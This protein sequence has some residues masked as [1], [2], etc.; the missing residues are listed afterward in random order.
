MPLNLIEE[1]KRHFAFDSF[2][3]G[4]LEAIQHVLNRQNT[5]VVMPTGAGKSLCYQLPALLNSDTTL[6]VSP[7]IALMKDQVEALQSSGKTAT[8]I[9]SSLTGP[10]Q[11][12]RVQAMRAGQF[13]LVY[14][15][16]ERFR[17]NAFLAAMADVA[18]SLFVV[19]EAHCI[20]QWGHDFRPDYL[21]LKNVISQVRNPTVAALTATATVKVQDDIIR[22][23]GLKSCEK[24]ITGF[25]R[26]NLTFEVEYTPDDA[27]KLRIIEELLTS[28][29]DSGIIYTGTRR[30]A[31][32]VAEFVAQYCK[33]KTDFYHAGLESYDRSRIQD[34]FMNDEISVIVATNAFGMGVDKSDIRYVIH[35][36]LPSSLEA[37]YQEAGRAGRDGKLSRCVLLYSPKDRALQEWFIENDAPTKE[38]LKGLYE[39]IKNAA[40]DR[41]V[42]IGLGYLQRMT[43][44]HETKVRVGIAELVKAHALTDLGDDLGV[45]NLEILPIE[46]LDVALNFQQIKAR[47]KY[48]YQQLHQVIRYA[49]GNACRRRFILQHFG[50]TGI[51]EAERCCDNCLLEE[52]APAKKHASKDDYTEA[53]KAA[54]IILHA[55]K[56]LKREVGRSRLVE[57]LTGSK[58]QPIFEFGWHKAKHYGRLQQLTQSR[59]RDF[60]DQLLKQRYLKIVGS[61]YP[62]LHLTPKG[63]GALKQLAAIPLEYKRAPTPAPSHSPLSRIARLPDTVQQTLGLFRQGM[64]AEE[65]AER[66]ELTAG[67]IYGH[68]S[69]LI[70]FG[71]VQVT[72]IVPVDRVQQ[73]REAIK[74]VGVTSLKPIKERLPE[75]ISYDEIRCVVEDEVGNIK[76]YRPT[77]NDSENNFDPELFERLRTFRLQLAKEANL[78]PFIFFHDSVLQSLAACKPQTIE[79]LYQVKGLGDNKISKYGIQL[80]NVI[81]TSEERAAEKVGGRGSSRSVNDF[82]RH[83]HPKSLKGP[84]TCGY[85]LDFNS[86]FSGSQW[87]RTELGELVYQ[88]KYNGQVDVAN[89]LVNRIIRF[90]DDHPEFNKADAVLAVPPSRSRA[91]DPM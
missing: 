66:R 57:I 1:L 23:L 19:D 18:V 31:E 71:L 41:F 9:N 79:E 28:H 50:D 49:E 37:Y 22:Q 27:S 85:A 21:T 69:Q 2:R 47:R 67:T 33:R 63:E 60:V 55:V 44:L 35:Y 58:A 3:P 64:S 48:K 14:V 59:C 81:K 11:N 65:I 38:E 8:F 54:L 70:A 83:P 29:S 24:I 86:R 6:V 5:L 42:R 46:K 82:L 36:S 68:F 53:E 62:I 12:Q 61:D 15:S 90:L 56:Y 89:E 40:E 32:E 25:N 16:P 91:F 4:Q 75:E 77:Q 51:A 34:A 84:W 80:L 13:R 88:F 72:A 76:G 78:P 87:Q 45:M 74:Q 73:I 43:G 30:E 26:P 7:L 20:S 39:I 52:S 17:S 10:E